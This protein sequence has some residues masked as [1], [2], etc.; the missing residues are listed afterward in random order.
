MKTLEDYRE[1]IKARLPENAFLKV[2]RGSALFVSDAPTRR[3]DCDIRIEGWK[4]RPDKG[5]LYIT[6]ALHE[7]PEA[8][9]DVYIHTLKRG[10]AENQKE[11]RQRLACCMRSKQKEETAFLN[12]LLEREVIE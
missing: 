11:I 12:D 8:I 9:R 3:T 5:L 2:D 4:C 10:K 1:E 7:V 6:P